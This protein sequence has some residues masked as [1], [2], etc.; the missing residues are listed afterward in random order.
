M[1]NTTIKEKDLGYQV[2]VSKV[3]SVSTVV[4]WDF[5]LSQEG[6]N[7]WLGKIDIDDFEIQKPLVTESGNEYKITVYV[8][9]C[10]FR[11]KFKPMHWAKASIV[12][13]RVINRK[14]KAGLTFYQTS[15]FEIENREEMRMYWK[16]VIPKMTTSI[17]N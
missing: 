14:G 6:I 16:G 7:L 15:F 11:F 10:H 4:M 17:N 3:F 1:T 9:N 5:L 12:E 13:M 8:P 2:S